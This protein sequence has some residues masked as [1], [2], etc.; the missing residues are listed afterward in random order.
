[1]CPRNSTRSATRC[2]ERF[3]D[4]APH[5]ETEAHAYLA[6]HEQ[7]RRA[8]Q[9]IEF[10]VVE[11]HD[12]NVVL[13]GASLNNV[14]LERDARPSATGW[15]R[16]PAGAASRPMPSGS[17]ARWAFE[18]LELA[19]LELTCGPDNRASQG[20]AE[21]CGFTRE[22]VLRSQIP[23]KARGATRSSS[24][25]FPANCVESRR[26]SAQFGVARDH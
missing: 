11:P 3:S 23:F 14:D 25:C 5:T 16:T 9:H 4:W 12:D 8:G 19:R 13:G 2:F 21:R 18:E 22:G 6:E 1:M 26:E 20:V 15:R 10:A 17:S 24:A 7:A